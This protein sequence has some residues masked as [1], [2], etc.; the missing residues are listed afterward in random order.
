MYLELSSPFKRVN[1]I[2]SSTLVRDMVS[3]ERTPLCSEDVDV[4]ANGGSVISSRSFGDPGLPDRLLGAGVNLPSSAPSIDRPPDSVALV[5][6]GLPRE[7]MLAE[8]GV[9]DRIAESLDGE[10]RF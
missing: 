6:C 9:G 5:T 4:G 1:D 2:L 8:F 10:L 7:R 3:A